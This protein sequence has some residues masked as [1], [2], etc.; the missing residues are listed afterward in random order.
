M[1]APTCHP[2]SDLPKV[3]RLRQIFPDSTAPEIEPTV[4][5][6]LKSL[7]PKLK[8]GM[9][10]AV[11]VGSRGITNLAPIIKQVIETLKEFGTAPYIVPAMGSHG[12]ATA[13]AQ[14]ELLNGY[15][16]SEATLDI[17]IASSME[18][19]PIDSTELGETL[20]WS[21]EALK[22]DGVIVV[23]R[24]KPHTDFAGNLGSGLIK[25]SVVGL[26][27]QVGASLFHRSA[28]RNGY[29]S[30]LRH[31]FRALK[32]QTPLL[33]GLALIEDQR[34]NTSH[35]EWVD[36]DD[37]EQTE[38]RLLKQARE[39]MPGIPFS[40]VDLLI[41]DRIG[42]NISGAGMDP[43]VIGRSIHGYLTSPPTK[44]ETLSIRRIYVRGLTPET[45]G[46][47]IGIGLADATS[48][49]LV[50]EMDRE[51]TS[52]NALTALSTNGA[53]I[54]I[55]FAN[56][57]EAIH[58]VLDT[59]ALPDLKEAKILR[60][61]DTLNLERLQA[62]SRLLEEARSNPSLV[63]ESDEEALSFDEKGQLKH[64]LP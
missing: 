4:R 8:P 48:D 28:S 37:L 30:S 64:E 13:E 20:V 58:R 15:G 3:A 41:I 6:E 57:R 12:G 40:W 60:I 36:V 38:E 18:V 9:K 47:A 21:Q 55:H 44:P 42:K 53:K 29:E 50:E 24:I 46:N 16:V 39:L 35:I 7:A 59:L 5:T 45:H 17:P 49:R 61:A 54:P 26:G 22:A 63:I 33:G 32:A 27:K 51:V 25:M 31:R 52:L 56:D 14:A 1:N 2:D 34:H 43:N 23:N 62:S 11:G 10:I 19:E